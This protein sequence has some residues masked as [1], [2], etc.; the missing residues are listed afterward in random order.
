M[1][2]ELLF[3]VI[4]S[5]M[6]GACTVTSKLKTTERNLNRQAEANANTPPVINKPILAD[7]DISMTRATVE[8][9]TTNVDMGVSTIETK[10]KKTSAITTGLSSLKNEAKNRAQFFFMSEHNCDF[11]IDPIYTVQVESVSESNVVN[12]T[13]TISAFPA[14]YKKFS[15]PDSLPKSIYQA[16]QV[17]SRSL[18]L[19]ISSQTK[20]STKKV[21]EYGVVGGFGFSNVLFPGNTDNKKLAFNA[22]LYS[23]PATGFGLRFEFRFSNMGYLTTE[24]NYDP[25]TGNNIS[26]EAKYRFTSLMFPILLNANIKKFNLIGGISPTFHISGAKTIG[27]TKTT[28]NYNDGVDLAFAIGIAYKINDDL[29]IGLRHDRFGGLTFQNTGLNIGYRIK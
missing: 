12:F 1:K 25:T 28:V 10:G 22:G 18:P 7:L 2:K 13:V 5:L 21:R 9:K 6:F 3:V 24:T 26:Q 19:Y 29:M 11:L 15:Q 23:A 16:S 8:Y 17:G 27:S 4:T 20:E 14:R